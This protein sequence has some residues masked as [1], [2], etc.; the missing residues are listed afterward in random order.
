[1]SLKSVTPV[2]SAIAITTGNA[3]AAWRARDQ[4]L[5][6]LAQSQQINAQLFAIFSDLDQARIRGGSAP[7]EAVLARRLEDAGNKLDSRVI[8]DLLTLA[9][10]QA[11][12]GTALA[13]LG[14]HAS[15]CR[16]LAPCLPILAA[17]FGTDHPT[18][19]EIND[20]LSQA[21]RK[22]SLPEPTSGDTTSQGNA[23]PPRMGG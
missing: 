23:K 19:R 13:G 20:L 6:A 7:L 21:R 2:I 16:F 3:I 17:H 5:A 18:P 14:A 10:F 8:P 11:Q 22:A 1:M 9:T 12:L 15:A 4:A